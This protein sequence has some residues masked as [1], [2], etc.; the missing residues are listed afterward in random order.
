MRELTRDSVSLFIQV[1]VAYSKHQM[2]TAKTNN[3][4]DLVVGQQSPIALQYKGPFLASVDQQPRK[5]AGLHR[6]KYKGLT[7]VLG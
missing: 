4:D 2:I 1:S 6:Y 5:Q 7:P 3:K